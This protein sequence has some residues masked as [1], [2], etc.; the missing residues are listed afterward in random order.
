MD[1]NLID[2]D[3]TFTSVVSCI[4]EAECLAEYGGYEYL[5]IAEDLGDDLGLI[6]VFRERDYDPEA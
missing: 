2:K 6:A 5:G 4:A 1:K 3:G